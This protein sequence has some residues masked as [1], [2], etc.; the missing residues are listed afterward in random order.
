[1]EW[2]AEIHNEIENELIAWRSLENADINNAGSVTFRGVP[3][4]RG[5]EMKV[6]LSYEPPLGLVGSGIARV[7]GEEPEQQLEDDLQRFKQLMETG[8]IPT[9]HGQS[10]GKD[11]ATRENSGL[12]SSSKEVV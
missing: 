1:V 10:S 4:G 12:V 6:V 2:D 11:K 7:F 5:T 3:E 8:E 9:T